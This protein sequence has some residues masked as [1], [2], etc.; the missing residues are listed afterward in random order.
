MLLTNAWKTYNSQPKRQE[1]TPA[2]LVAGGGKILCPGQGNGER[3]VAW[4]QATSILCFF[5]PDLLRFSGLNDKLR[6]AD[7]N[8]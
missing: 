8:D 7:N 5:A 3:F 4:L 6:A 1:N 2:A